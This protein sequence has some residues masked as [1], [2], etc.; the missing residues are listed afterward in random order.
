MQSFLESTLLP[1][2]QVVFGPL[3]AGLDRLPPWT[4]RVGVIL[5]ILAGALWVL[6]LKKESIFAGSPSDSRVRDLRLWVPIVLLPYVLI[7]LF[8]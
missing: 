3:H 5:Y 7:Y 1:V 4:W 2:L 8:L 6:F